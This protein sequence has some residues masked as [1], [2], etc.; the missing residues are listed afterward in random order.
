MKKKSFHIKRFIKKIS[1]DTYLKINEHYKNHHKPV[2]LM[3][4]PK[5]PYT[6][7]KLIDNIK[8]EFYSNNNYNNLSIFFSKVFI[9]FAKL[10]FGKKVDYETSYGYCKIF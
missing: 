8:I 1:S 4:E 3:H 10:M 6:N 5:E 2:I 7:T 9:K